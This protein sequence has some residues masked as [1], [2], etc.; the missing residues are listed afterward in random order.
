MAGC[1]HL[2]TA[3]S[4]AALATMTIASPAVAQQ[5]PV[6]IAI[7]A[8]SL[9]QALRMFGR[10]AHIQLAFDE[11]LL[12]TRTAPPLVG[13]MTVETGLDRL[14]QGS[15]LA[16]ARTPQ[17]VYV[18]SRAAGLVPA[19]LTAQS[20]T[21]GP[22]DAQADR[23]DDPSP[24]GEDVVVTG[25]RIRS[26]NLVETAPVTSVG[27]AEIKLQSAFSVQEVLNRVPA[28]KNSDTNLSNGNGRQQ[29]D[30]HGLGTN[31]TLTLIDGQRIGVTEGID[32][33]VIPVGLIERVD[34]L[35][36]GASAVYG[37]DAIGGVV[38]FILRKDF[39]GLNANIN[40]GFYNADN[41]DN[42]A[43]QAARNSGFAVPTG[44]RNDGGRFD[45]NISIG[46]NFAG[47]RGNVALF[48]AYS[49]VEPVLA[50]SRSFSVCPITLS[51]QTVV[52]ASPSSATPAGYFQAL[53]GPAQTG[54]IFT[55]AADG[56][57]AFAPYTGTNGYNYNDAFYFQRQ[58]TRYNGAVFLNY[59]VSPA[60]QL[61]ANGLYLR[62][63]ATSQSAP[64]TIQPGSVAY[65]I[66]C[67]NPLLSAQQ[68]QSLCGTA[69]G[70]ATSVTTDVRYRF[71]APQIT[72]SRNEI[73]RGVAGVRGDLGS[74]WHYDVGGVYSTTLY[75]QRQ[76]N[77]VDPV[78]VAN[79]LQ[80]VDV[81]GVA[82]CAAA[83]SNPGCVPLDIFTT[84]G[85]SAAAIDYVSYAEGGGLFRERYEQWVGNANITG[86]LGEYGIR[87]PF[88]SKG[89]NVALG[90]EYRRNTYR[91]NP[92]AAYT[93][94]FGSTANSLSNHAFDIYGEI[95]VPLVSDRPFVRDL[96]FGA[97]IR[98]SDYSGVDKMR[99]TYKIDGSWRPVEDLLLRASYNKATRAP[100]I[101]ELSSNA[102]VSY[103]TLDA[104]TLGDPC[105]GATPS[106]SLAVC[107]KSGVTAAQYG[108]IPQCPDNLCTVRNG[109]QG[110][111]TPEI[112]H[113]YTYGLVVTPHWLRGLS[114][115]ADYYSIQIEN[116]IGYYR[117]IDF[118]QT[119][120]NTGYDFFCGQLVRNAD[121]SLFSNTGSTS[122]YINQGYSNL[123]K[124]NARGFNFSANYDRRLGGWAKLSTSYVATLQTAKGG[125]LGLPDTDFNVV[126][127]F[128]PYA[129]QGYRR[130]QHNVRVTL[131]S[132]DS[133][134]TQGLVS[135]NWR[136]NSGL[137]NSRLDGNP[138]FG[139]DD[140]SVPDAY[141]YLPAYD[142]FDLSTSVTV[143]R[144]LTL[145]VVVNNIFNTN[146]P[147]RPSPPLE[148]AERVNTSPSVYDAL[149]RSINMGA[150]LNF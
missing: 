59:E 11:A 130:Y 90:T 3:V 15:G 39:E 10:Q 86:D 60:I 63:D 18:I 29:F 102:S 103:G 24:D 80:V 41:R 129:G 138:I 142:L 62:S 134:K 36:G 105:A 35:T 117:A 148:A 119:C 9:G 132:P 55:N 2:F 120:A 97:A 4:L 136:H 33:S 91:S 83:A 58:N 115:T 87:S 107:Q 143:S 122:G 78:K 139:A 128:G 65:S 141:K 45:A 12:G 26:K 92:D 150:T 54:A 118:L 46:H 74:A 68:A 73:Y 51:G 84:A 14:L 16:V 43:A 82:T 49:Q 27:Q 95:N 79:A 121:G 70:T 146:P 131:A 47:G 44:A 50:T 123:G 98:G 57:R 140:A 38:N 93:A 81:N 94:A 69:A 1:R 112:A 17:G 20:D 144:S 106:A 30:F 66:N 109:S 22:V 108:T 101:Y 99:S 147:V 88:S 89:V 145:R 100:S 72:R 23:Q 96:S 77:R 114:L 64:A 61:Y 40:Y 125:D 5:R 111:V 75:R 8:Q 133:A 6:R 42:I 104:N 19:A 113:T 52:C 31:R 124:T 32:A 127:L 137:K 110:L 71:S 34:L 21:V 53:S 76:L 85:P 149:G 25:S 126:G 7:K 67:D 13:S 116:G 135:L 37:S 56:A 48:G 28:I